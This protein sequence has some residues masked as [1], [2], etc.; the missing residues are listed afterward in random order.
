MLHIT[1]RTIMAITMVTIIM[2]MITITDMRRMRMPTVMQSIGMVREV[3]SP[4]GLIKLQAWLS[5]AFPVGSF[6]YSHGL[7]SAVGLVAD[8]AGLQK[9]LAAL[10]GFGS[11]WNDAVL[12][13]ETWR[14]A[15]MG[16][17]ITELADLG[18]ALAGSCERHT[19]TMLQGAAFRVAALNGWPHPVL[20]RLPA[21]C[22][23][24]VA[25]GT[26]AGAHGLP[27][28]PA[29]AVFLQAFV[30]NLAQAAIRLGVTGQSG[31][32]AMLAALECDVVEAAGRAANSTL[33]DLGSVAIVS[34]IMSMKHETHYSRLFR[35]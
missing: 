26:A 6:S 5:P 12:F 15:S 20:D 21:A 34:E 2:I 9:W 28:E 11:G 25:V 3:L 14:R 27:L 31:A 1:I 18:E 33:D 32:T 8:A 29:I 24:A 10:I 7:E 23:Y 17:N 30:A 13:A 35:S 16:G 4:A 22:P 19:E